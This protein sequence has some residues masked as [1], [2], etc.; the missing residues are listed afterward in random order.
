MGSHGVKSLGLDVFRLSLTRS[1]RLTLSWCRRIS[2][3][4]RRWL[5][6]SL[7][8][9]IR[10]RLSIS[11]SLRLRLRLRHSLSLRRSFRLSLR[12][13]VS[14]FP[15]FTHSVRLVYN[16]YPGLFWA[17]KIWVKL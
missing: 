3:C 2:R 9:S 10:L 16:I 17:K 11:A 4:S 6:R 7:S 12:L 14:M 1:P 8:P 13:S 5:R 15:F